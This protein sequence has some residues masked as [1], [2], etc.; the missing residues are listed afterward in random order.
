MKKP[1][2]FT[3]LFLWF[4]NFLLSFQLRTNQQSLHGAWISKNGG[5]ETVLLFIDG[6]CTQSI[7]DK[8]NKKFI[9]TRGGPFQLVDNRLSIQYEFD[10]KDSTMVNQNEIL[11]FV[12]DGNTL[13]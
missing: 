10:T 7:Y 11:S 5:I 13:S 3:L 8:G 9:E 6:Y 2:L 1:L 12:L 4:I